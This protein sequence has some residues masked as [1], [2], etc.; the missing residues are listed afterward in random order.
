[1]SG[2]A[3]MWPATRPAHASH[4]TGHMPAK[5]D[6]Q[7]SERDT[8]SGRALATLPSQPDRRACFGHQAL[9]RLVGARLQGGISYPQQGFLDMTELTLPSI[10]GLMTPGDAAALAAEATLKRS[11]AQTESVPF[12]AAKLRA[13]ADGLEILATR[14]RDPTA[15]GFPEFR[16]GQGGEVTPLP[17]PRMPLCIR[18][19]A[20][21]VQS[22]PD[23]LTAEA[24]M[25]RLTL[26]REAG[27]LT[28]AVEAAESVGAEGA[29][30]QMLVHGITAAHAVGMR[31]LAAAN[32]ALQTHERE[33]LL[34]GSGSA[35][36][37][38]GRSA[39]AAARLMDSMTRATAAL[40]RLRHGGCQHVTVQH[41]VVTEGGQAV[42]AGNVE[43]G[44]GSAV[45]GRRR[46]GGRGPK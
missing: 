39:V 43:A 19:V 5:P 15:F 8:R 45:L 38:A 4:T 17:E 24:T 23:T 1:M 16:I 9:W 37:D 22:P 31:L 20:E 28:Q 7:A 11:R 41:L 46:K 3:G 40:D 14:L 25:G 27:V 29:M 35:L 10:T 30:E 21:A 33:R 36:V 13:E 12:A 18:D 26:A 6:D 34:S 42:V 2:G 44:G 32:T